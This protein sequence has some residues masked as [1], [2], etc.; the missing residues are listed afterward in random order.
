M[1]STMGGEKMED[2]NEQSIPEQYRPVSTWAFVGYFLLCCIPIVNI[3]CLIIFACSDSN[4]NRRN[5]ARAYLVIF[6]IAIVLYMIGWASLFNA[7]SSVTNDTLKTYEESRTQML[8]EQ[9][10][11]YPSLGILPN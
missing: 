6:G 9:N 11:Y 4:I 3:V 7:S 5:F 10:N 1:N 8:Q 2:F